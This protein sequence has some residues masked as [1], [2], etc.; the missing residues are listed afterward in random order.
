ATRTV[1][2]DADRVDAQVARS[3]ATVAAMPANQV[4]FPGNALTDV[5]TAH[6]LPESFDHADELVPDLHR[7]RNGPLRPLVPVI[8]VRV[9]PA[10]RGLF[11]PDKYGVRPYAGLGNVV[12]PDTPLLV[13]F[14]HCF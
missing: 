14:Y 7:H 8:D 10:D 4:A 3:R 6:G 12:H 13:L 1:N 5:Q 11:D 2:P 9:G